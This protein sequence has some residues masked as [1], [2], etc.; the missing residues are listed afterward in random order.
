MVV[1]WFATHNLGCLNTIFSDLASRNICKQSVS[2]HYA[3]N[4]SQLY[5][6]YNISKADIKQ[7]VLS[8]N[9]PTHPDFAELGYVHSASL[10]APFRIIAQIRF[11]L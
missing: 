2:F 5:Y 8:D 7:Y 6:R 11:F 1:T 9:D 4:A 3:L 10:G